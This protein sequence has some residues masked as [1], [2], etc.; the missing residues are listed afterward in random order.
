MT[1]S[2]QLEDAD[3]QRITQS[4]STLR[5]SKYYVWGAAVAVFCSGIMTL[6][7]VLTL[8]GAA[9]AT[10]DVSLFLQ[11]IV[12]ASLASELGFVIQGAQVDQVDVK[13]PKF[14]QDCLL[15]VA[16]IVCFC[17]TETH[18]TNSTLNG[19]VG[20]LWLLPS[21]VRWLFAL[22]ESMTLSKQ[23]KSTASATVFPTVS[24]TAVTSAVIGTLMKF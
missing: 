15:V 13:H 9:P 18:P 8:L 11:V 4:Y 5:S 21:F 16:A 3:T 23:A 1:G 6:R 7:S 2:S 22:Q 20:L 10:D 24:K 19:S 17:I 14:K 12:V